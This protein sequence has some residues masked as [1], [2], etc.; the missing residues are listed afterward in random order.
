MTGEEVLVRVEGW[1]S[2]SRAAGHATPRW[3]S[4]TISGPS[5]LQAV[6]DVIVSDDEEGRCRERAEVRAWAEDAQ[7]NLAWPGPAES[8]G[9][10]SPGDE[11]SAST[12]V[13]SLA[14]G[15]M[16]RVR[17][18]LEH[19]HVVYGPYD[20]LLG[21][22]TVQ[23]QLGSAGLR[24][25]LPLDQEQQVTLPRP[26]QFEVP[27]E[28]RDTQYY[29]S[30]PDSLHVAAHLPGSAYFRF[31]EIPVRY[32]TKMRLRF[33]YLVAAGTEGTCRARVTQFK[34]SPV[35][36]KVLTDGRREVPLTLVGRWTQVELVFRTEPKATTLALDFR[37]EGDGVEVGEFWIDDLSLEPVVA[38]T[39][40]P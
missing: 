15:V 20:P 14:P 40:D 38:A 25:A 5:R 33:S 3:S 32:D 27:E 9:Q 17:L 36:W 8:G 4:L 1:V 23:L 6:G 7:G 39:R 28:H 22:R 16:V 13:L 26:P 12:T 19:Q 21:L 29:C 2:N 31:A 30:G 37:I 35:A 24:D 34:D 18:R 11:S 10:R